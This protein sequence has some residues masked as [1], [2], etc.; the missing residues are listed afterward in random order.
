MKWSGLSHHSTPEAQRVQ[1]HV[2]RAQTASSGPAGM[3]SKH[4]ALPPHSPAPKA[5]RVTA[6]QKHKRRTSSNKT[7]VTAIGKDQI[8]KRH[9][10]ILGG[11]IKKHRPVF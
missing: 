9:F 1:M 3:G 5:S 11:Q 4:W 7:V 8:Q 10:R 6:N 2:S